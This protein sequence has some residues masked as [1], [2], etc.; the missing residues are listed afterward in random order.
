M[1]GNVFRMKRAWFALT[2]LFILACWGGARLLKARNELAKI[3]SLLPVAVLKGDF[4]MKVQATGAVD[5]E[6]RV[7]LAPSVGGRLEEIFVKEGDP[8]KKGQ[9]IAK[10]SSSERVALLDSVALDS[11]KSEEMAIVRDAY[12]LMPLVSPIDGE[13]IKRAAEPGQTVSPGKEIVVISDRLIIKTAVDETDIG[14]VREGQKAEFYLDAFQ[15]QR[16]EGAVV[17]VSRDS[18]KKEGVN[19]YEVKVL[20]SKPIAALRS[21]MTADVYILTGVKKNTLYLPKRAIVYKDGE[22]F[23]TVKAPDGKKS[24]EQKVQT[25]KANEKS[26]EI[27]SGISAGE[28]VL[29]S[30]DTIK[31]ESMA[32]DFN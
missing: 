8:V 14:G 5:P 32:I 31:P 20:P 10:I 29:Y 16:H 3:R 7:P 13:I 6:N 9:L 24:K 18:T 30:S 19:V 17:A 22:S 2:A 4:T 25:G 28:T 12:T 11:S 1:K 27:L 26:I 15:K 21:G 23:V